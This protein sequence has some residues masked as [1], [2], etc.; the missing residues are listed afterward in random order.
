MV[1]RVDALVLRTAN[2]QAAVAFYRAIGIPLKEE[3]EPGKPSLYA[4]KLGGIM[5]ALSEAPPGKGGE[6]ERAALAT[7]GFRV[8]SVEKAYMASK[9]GGGRIVVEP[10]DLPWGRRAV[11]LDP[12]GRPVE[13]SERRL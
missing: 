4:C 5:F 6:P 9:A 7:V 12:D 1:R 13:F 10:Q 11:V 3:R 2:L 8:D